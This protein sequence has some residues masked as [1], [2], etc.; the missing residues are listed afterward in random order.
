LGIDGDA[1]DWALPSEEADYPKLSWQIV[2]GYSGGDGSAKNPYQIAT[3]EDIQDLSNTPLHWNRCFILTSDIDISGVLF[4]VAPI[5]PCIT[6][7]VRDFQDIPFTG[8]FDGNGHS[9]HNLTITAP[10]KD[11]I[12]LF[13]CISGGQIRN[14]GLKNVNIQGQG[15]VGGLAGNNRGTIANCYSNGLVK[16]TNSVGG[17][18][19][20][21]GGYNDYYSLSDITNCHSTCSVSGN[22][23]IGGLVGFNYL[24]KITFCYAAGAVSGSYAGGLVGTTMSYVVTSCFWDTETSGCSFSAGAIGKT[25]AEMKT[26]STFTDAGWDFVGETANGT[27]D[28][29]AISEGKDYPRFA[30]GNTPP[31]ADAGEDQTACAWIDGN[32]SIAL[33]GSDSNDVD[34]DVLTYSWMLDSEVIATECNAVVTLP[35]GVHTL[36]LKVSDGVA[37]SS[38]DEVVITVIA[39][40]QG[41]LMIVPSAINRQSQMPHIM[42]MFQLPAGIHKLDGK[43]TLYPGGVECTMQRTLCVNK[44]T[45]VFAWF[46]KQAVMQANPK[47]GIT[48]LTLVGKQP[49]GPYIY[50]KDRVLIFK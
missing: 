42:A 34:G 3:V 45:T 14:M 47:N 16:G 35:V 15:L 31:V 19:G 44:K 1:A 26:R 20:A 2:P 29:W 40:Q 37:E 39:A 7:P 33:N 41:N 18:V 22:N 27:N 4:T 46:D 6:T 5:A 12:G 38:P 50:G 24:G 25:T 11:Y 28:V 17:L 43:V 49:D 36:S 9:I 10:T 32:A 21:T 23:F 8:V 30:M 48:E 13:G